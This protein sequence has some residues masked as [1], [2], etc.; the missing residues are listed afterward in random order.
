MMA[1]KAGRIPPIRKI[2]HRY[3][4]LSCGGR[5]IVFQR[6]SETARDLAL[7][8]ACSGTGRKPQEVADAERR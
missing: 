3:A 1:G 2:D 7:C 6:V 8:N 4:C 5:G